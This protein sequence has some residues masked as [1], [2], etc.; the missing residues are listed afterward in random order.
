MGFY[1]YFDEKEYRMQGT[2]EMKD[3]QE[4]KLIKNLN[5]NFDNNEVFRMSCIAKGV[6]DLS[7]IKTLD[8][9]KSAF[10]VGGE[11]RSQM[12]DMIKGPFW[13]GTLK[14]TMAYVQGVKP[15]DYLL[16]C[17]TSGT[18]G[19]PTPYFFTEQS[20]QVMAKGYSRGCF[21]C[22]ITP[23]E[24]VV[25]AMALS[26]FGAGIPLIETFIRLGV[27]VIPVGAEVGK[28]KL[29]QFSEYFKPTIM[30]CT[31]SYAQYLVEALPEKIRSLRFKRVICGGE[32]GAGIPEVR[33]KIQDGFGCRLTDMMGLIG[34]LALA[35]C[36]VEEYAGMHHLSDDLFFF[37]LVDPETKQSIPFENGAIGQLLTT[38]LEGPMSLRGTSGD[39]A[40]VLTEPCAC[41]NPG[42]RLKIIGRTDDMLKVKGVIVYPSHIDDAINHFVPKVTGEFRIVLDIPPPRVE[43]PLKLKV[44]YAGTVPEASLDTLA[45][46]I[47][48]YMHN[49]LRIRPKIEW[50]PPMSLERTALKTRYIE[51]TYK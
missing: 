43:P 49:K 8:D 32:P 28:E 26:M 11:P 50:V 51:K 35:S 46:E 10:P 31:P 40:Q 7:H 37:E 9:F 47:G 19:I 16:L 18:T 21:M 14:D 20:M 41:G 4:K 3:L 38:T 5:D 13:K 15:E 42:W 48:D 27:T 23:G 24:T 36:D 33:N 17:A 34:G 29:M 6:N 44:E 2:P 22:G 39:V 30:F 12:E 45:G 25:H 1:D